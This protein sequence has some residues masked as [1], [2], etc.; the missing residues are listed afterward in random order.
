MTFSN[1]AFIRYGAL[2]VG[3]VLAVAQTCI[4][5]SASRS[6]AEFQTELLTGTGWLFFVFLAPYVVLALIMCE[7]TLR[8][9]LVI[10]AGSTL[11][12][13]IAMLA[14][15]VTSGGHP[16]SPIDVQMFDPMLLIVGLQIIIAVFA[17]RCHR[18]R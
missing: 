13:G 8:S 3:A 11:A 2:V 6:T 4:L 5:L 16:I 1:N 18:G 10:G 14:Y 17:A 9:R 12:L 15:S 7:V